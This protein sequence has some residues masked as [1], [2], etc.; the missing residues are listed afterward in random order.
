MT[1]ALSEAARQL[2][3]V[4]R[5]YEELA[6][7]YRDIAHNAALAES[8]YRRVKAQT[9]LRATAEGAS[10]AKAEIMADADESVS[11][12]CLSYKIASAL[13]DAT[14]AKLTQ[15]RE[16]VAVGRSMMVGEREADRVHAA[17]ST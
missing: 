16:Q 9:M 5:A 8:E 15:L 13:A 11:R 17:R 6:N 14:R 1:G 10:A 2:G 4:S 12:L 7:E 3:K